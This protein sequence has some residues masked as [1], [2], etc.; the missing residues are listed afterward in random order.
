MRRARDSSAWR[1]WRERGEDRAL[2]PERGDDVKSIECC[3][4]KHADC[5]WPGENCSCSCH[6]KRETNLRSGPEPD[7]ASGV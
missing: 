5:Y 4:G 3:S 6:K 1:G 2:L 7:L